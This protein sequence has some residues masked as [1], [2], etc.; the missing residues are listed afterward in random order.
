MKEK[1]LELS[2]KFWNA[3]EHSDEAGMRAVADPQCNFVHIGVTCKLDKEIEFYTS[4]AFQPTELVFNSKDPQ[5]FGDTGI[6]ITDCN[7]GLLL[8]GKP[9][10]HHFAVTEVYSK[11]NG[12]WKLV[13]FTFTALVY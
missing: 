3:M 13:S 1:L 2:E 5:I 11:M 9:T 7:Y 10:T 6:V 4:G 8:G 12:E